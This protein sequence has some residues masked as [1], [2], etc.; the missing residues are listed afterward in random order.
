MNKEKKQQMI[1]IVLI[2]IFLIGLIYMRSQQKPGQTAAGVGAGGEL[3]KPD[4]LTEAV[5]TPKAAF[6]SA[7]TPSEEDPFKN[8]LELYL[9]N[10]RKAK[11]QP[12]KEMLLP[13]P[14]L[15]IEGMIWNT[16]MPQAI[17]NGQVVRIDDT[18]EGV[19]IVKIEKQ[20][21]TVDHNGESVLI[22]RR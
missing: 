22:E 9:Y 10:M 21:I 6:D 13:L 19:R 8:L 16:N 11:V 7:Y 2:P 12:K 5:P 14:K 4:A 1:L 17:V 18:I 20:G 15:T 3:F